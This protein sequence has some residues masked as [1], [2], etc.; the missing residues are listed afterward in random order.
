MV[1]RFTYCNRHTYTTKFNQHRVVKTPGGRLVYHTT[2]KRASEPMCP[3][4][5]SRLPRN[6]ST[7]NC[8][9]GGILSGGAVREMIIRAF[10]VEEQQIMMILHQINYT[11]KL[12][13]K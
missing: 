6:R 1:H 13:S 8:A 4:K 2:K 11:E 12:L 7:V 9:Y 10:L 5:R 3:Y